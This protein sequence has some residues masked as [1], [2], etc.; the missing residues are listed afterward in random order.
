[1]KPILEREWDSTTGAMEKDMHPTPKFEQKSQVDEAERGQKL[2]RT[3]LSMSCL[4]AETRAKPCTSP[5]VVFL[6]HI[7]LPAARAAIEHFA[8][9]GNNAGCSFACIRYGAPLPNGPQ[10][11]APC[12]LLIICSLSVIV[13]RTCT[14][15]RWWLWHPHRALPKKA[16]NNGMWLFWNVSNRKPSSDMLSGPRL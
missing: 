12:S 2:F 10:H 15:F 11:L 5:V 8:T 6:L 9:H 16:L 3:R 13:A 14:F 7:W 4:S 1:M